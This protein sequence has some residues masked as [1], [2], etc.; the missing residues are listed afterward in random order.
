MEINENTVKFS[1]NN[2]FSWD[3]YE[4][5][6]TTLVL[7]AK[8]PVNVIWDLREMDK[9]PSM[10]II[11]KQILLMKTNKTKIKQNIIENIVYVKTN[12]LKSRIDWIFKNLYKPENPTKIISE[13]GSN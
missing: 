1:L 3:K 7:N 10:I 2:N 6:V 4:N 9:I 11:G 5:D 12:Y 8:K 13:E